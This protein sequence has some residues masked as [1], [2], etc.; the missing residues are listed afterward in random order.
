MKRFSVLTA[1][2]AMTLFSTAFGQDV[3]VEPP[4]VSPS[5]PGAEASQG[6]YDGFG[7]ELTPDTFELYYNGKNLYLEMNRPTRVAPAKT[8]ADGK[9]LVVL[10]HSPL[11]RA[12]MNTFQFLYPYPSRAF[13]DNSGSTRVVRVY[14]EKGYAI[15]VTDFGGPIDSPE[16]AKKALG[17]LTDSIKQQLAGKLEKPELITI[18]FAPKL[19]NASVI[20]VRTQLRIRYEKPIKDKNGADAAELHN[21]IYETVGMTVSGEDFFATVVIQ[22]FNRPFSR[23]VQDEVLTMLKSFESINN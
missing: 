16:S 22:M 8:P 11:Q 14:T 6:V 19:E 9:S 12:K 15:T 21:E 20:G 7:T 10:R 1:V 2:L 3:P 17:I 4:A 23:D 18:N 13:D 5:Q